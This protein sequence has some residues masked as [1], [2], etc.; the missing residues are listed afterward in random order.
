MN[1]YALQIY[2]SVDK[3]SRD[4][5]G[6]D[7]CFRLEF[8]NVKHVISNLAAQVWHGRMIVLS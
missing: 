1:V 4:T 2:H 8:T 3:S 5:I 6:L 7:K